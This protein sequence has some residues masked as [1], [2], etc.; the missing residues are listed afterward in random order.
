MADPLDEKDSANQ[1]NRFL[2]QSISLQKETLCRQEL[3]LQTPK[4]LTVAEGDW[5]TDRR[6]IETVNP[7]RGAGLSS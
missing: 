1:P 7:K 3:Q 5:P 6:A 4:K 2:V